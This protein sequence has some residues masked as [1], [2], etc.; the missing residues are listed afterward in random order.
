MLPT[1]KSVKDGQANGTQMT[2]EKVV[3]KPNEFPQVVMIG[4]NIPVN[5]VRAS[6]VA[7]IVVH[8]CNDRIRP[9]VFSVEPKKYTFRANIPKPRMLQERD[10]DRESVQMKAVQIPVLVNNATTGHKLQGC[11]VD[12]L[13]VHNWYY[14]T[15][16]A[17]VMLSR[18]RTW[19]GLYCRKKLSRDLSKYAVPEK[20]K[21]MLR[22]FERKAPTY[23]TE[24]QYYEK[25]GS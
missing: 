24:E 8:H 5:A 19:D 15:N 22:R 12:N 20:L 25:F 1:N 4:N 17:Y 13:F 7:H 9:Q 10:G 18:V 23:W 21:K 11:G 16:W 6:Q 14:V 3:L 2:F